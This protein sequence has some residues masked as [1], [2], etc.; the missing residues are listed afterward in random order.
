MPNTKTGK[1][2]SSKPIGGTHPCTTGKVTIQ[3]TGYEHVDKPQKIVFYDENIKQPTITKEEELERTSAKDFTYYQWDD[4]YDCPS[5]LFKWQQCNIDG[6]KLALEVEKEKGGKIYLPVA[7]K[8]TFD[9][10]NDNSRE[11]KSNMFLAFVPFATHLLWAKES[12]YFKDRSTKVTNN[13]SSDRSPR[14]INTTSSSVAYSSIRE[15]FLYLFVN[16][17]LW[18][19]LKVEQDET[20]KNWF[21]DI[22]L[23]DPKY[24]NADG[25]FKELKV[26]YKKTNNYNPKEDEEDERLAEG[27]PLEEIWVPYKLSNQPVS[28]NILFVEEQLSGPRINYLEN[29]DLV[30]TT[31]ISHTSYFSFAKGDKH[32]AE[33]YHTSLP[34]RLDYILSCKPRSQDEWRFDNPTAY[35]RHSINTIFGLTEI[36][37]KNCLQDHTPP[38]YVIEGNFTM[39]RTDRQGN[40]TSY[41]TRLFEVDAWKNILAKQY[42][43]DKT[44]DPFWEKDITKDNQIDAYKPRYIN[45]LIV[46]DPL[47]QVHRLEQLLSSAQAGDIFAYLAI[48][49]SEANHAKVGHFAYN[50]A[51]LFP[52]VMKGIATLDKDT[53]H[54]FNRSICDAERTFLIKR[55]HLWIDLLVKELEKDT[56]IEAFLNLL[57]NHRCSKYAGNQTFLRNSLAVLS[58]SP[59]AFDPLKSSLTPMITQGQVYVYKLACDTNSKAHQAL[60][61]HVEKPEE[62]QS[63]A[64]CP[65]PKEGDNLGDGKFYAPALRAIQQWNITEDNID[66]LDN[67]KIQAFALQGEAE[68]SSLSNL[69]RGTAKT[70]MS[71]VVSLVS[72]LTDAV[73]QSRKTL[74]D[75][76]KART[77]AIKAQIAE[78]RAK[79]QAQ[80]SS[81]AQ[82]KA[83]IEYDTKSIEYRQASQ[84]VDQIE[85]ARAK[86]QGQVAVNAEKVQAIQANNGK[87]FHNRMHLASIQDIR[88]AV[89]DFKQI[90]YIKVN[91]TTGARQG[92]I[93]LG[94]TTRE[95]LQQM[96]QF[97]K[98]GAR[99]SNTMKSG[100]LVDKYDQIGRVLGTTSSNAASLGGLKQVEDIFVLAIPANDSN[101]KLLNAY[102]ESTDHY[103]ELLLKKFTAEWTASTKAVAASGAKSTL[104]TAIKLSNADKVAAVAAENNA[105]ALENLM[106]N[107]YSQ[108]QAVPYRTRMAQEF[109]KTLSHPA[110]PGVLFIVEIWNLMTL[111][112]QRHALVEQG[113]ETRMQLGIA[114]ASFDTLYAYALMREKMQM[115][116]MGKGFINYQSIMGAKF[117]GPI[118]NLLRVRGIPVRGLL[119]G[120]LMGFTTF[121]N[122]WDMYHAMGEGNAAWVGYLVSGVGSGIL[123][124]QAL[125]AST[126][127]LCGVGPVGW[128]VIGISLM[129]IGGYLTLVLD[130]QSAV[131]EWFER[132]PFGTGGIVQAGKDTLQWLSDIFTSKELEADY[133]YLQNDQEEAIY[134]LI[135]ILLDYRMELSKVDQAA[136]NAE[137]NNQTS[138]SRINQQQNDVNQ[139]KLAQLRKMQQAKYKLSLT[140]NCA[141]L[142]KPVK[143][144]T[145]IAIALYEET[146]TRVYSKDLKWQ[147]DVANEQVLAIAKE[148]TKVDFYLKELQLPKGYIYFTKSTKLEVRMQIQGSPKNSVAG[149]EARYFPAPALRHNI[150]YNEARDSKPIFPSFSTNRYTAYQPFWYVAEMGVSS[151]NIK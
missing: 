15:G 73:E 100:F 56:T 39:A 81:T 148:T 21:K 142:I 59:E 60:W 114:S 68:A 43:D 113:H 94:L 76:T 138:Q 151:E 104:D 96:D 92:Y 66:Q 58:K 69:V 36:T 134:R 108:H 79:Q 45:G 3:V 19:E 103:L 1:K 83:Q 90:E 33:D 111:F 47:H 120:A 62:L 29:N 9:Q 110:I 145:K 119:G 89:E 71:G 14:A 48:R 118:A 10:A 67:P 23:S 70:G 63:P 99:T 52:E 146:H 105:V 86:Q 27:K 8:V 147:T 140:C 85:A 129:I 143:D 30:G 102:I 65:I 124:M 75:Y 13:Q 136:I 137:I 34:F 84:Q 133:S 87:V 131:E 107:A 18:R 80:T 49:S 116:N 117:N 17:K 135:S 61:P 55:M 78:A 5:T 82:N 72:I 24:R 50:M 139:K 28:A 31:A 106:N 12:N 26:T 91:P 57:S 16:G 38:S 35:L 88:L 132:G 98:A 25:T 121:I 2:I 130:R 101:R 32:L 128:L 123:T 144:T 127:V 115:A 46:P 7:E 54:Q 40:Y 44:I 37:D 22:D 97:I 141:N 11:Y 109:E 74:S 51:P 150:K 41:S 6:L 93:V 4:T 95:N 112:S 42:A 122:F 126:A 125:M 64:I 77:A 53:R 149:S 20:G